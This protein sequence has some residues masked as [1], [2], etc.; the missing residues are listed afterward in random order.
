MRTPASE[1]WARSLSGLLE[2]CANAQQAW[3]GAW[4]DLDDDYSTGQ[5]GRETQIC[6]PGPLEDT[7]VSSG[8]QYMNAAY[9]D[10][11]CVPPEYFNP[12]TPDDMEEV[13]DEWYC[14]WVN[15]DN[16]DECENIKGS[17]C[18]RSQFFR[19][20]NCDRWWLSAS[21]KRHCTGVGGRE[22]VIRWITSASRS[23][24]R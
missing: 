4:Y 12:I 19:W 1:R 7:F 16:C 22:S 14:I 18:A 3:E 2:N 24:C 23:P 21:Q 20:W 11:S 8:L 5:D 10:M 17:P 6:I 13:E 15:M 9:N